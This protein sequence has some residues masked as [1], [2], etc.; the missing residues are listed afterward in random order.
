MI[1][2]IP[3]FAGKKP[4]L[5]NK[6]DG[7]ASLSNFTDRL[8]YGNCASLKALLIENISDFLK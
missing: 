8:P 1:S 3:S 6:F 7:I 2:G 4:M 5:L